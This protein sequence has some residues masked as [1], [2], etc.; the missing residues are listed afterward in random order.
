MF[1]LCFSLF[2]CSKFWVVLYLSW[3]SKNWNVRKVNQSTFLKGLWVHQGNKRMNIIVNREERSENGQVFLWQKNKL[4]GQYSVDE[5]RKERKDWGITNFFFLI[6]VLS[7][8]FALSVVRITK[9]VWNTLHLNYKLEVKFGMRNQIKQ[10]A[11][12]VFQS[13]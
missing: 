5:T 13:P 3:G 2:L 4:E 1:P 6:L 12:H 8:W 11:R 10:D 7:G 9:D